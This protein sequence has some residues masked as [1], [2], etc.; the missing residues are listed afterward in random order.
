MIHNA[1]FYYQP[2]KSS[3]TDPSNHKYCKIVRPT[4]TEVWQKKSKKV[5]CLKQFSEIIII[6]KS[7]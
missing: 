4:L 7:Y 5:V 3:I 1:A 6:W 2:K